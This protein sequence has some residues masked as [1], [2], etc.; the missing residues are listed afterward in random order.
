MEVYGK[1]GYLLAKN[2]NTLLY[3]KNEEAREIQLSLPPL[4]K[5]KNDPFALLAAS[6]QGKHQ[7]IAGDLSSLEVNVAVMEILEAAK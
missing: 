5:E 1:E 6:I 3:R 2:T 4:S 7:V